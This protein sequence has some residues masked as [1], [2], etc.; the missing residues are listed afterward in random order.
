MKA[1]PAWISAMNPV[2][3]HAAETS[4][5]TSTCLRTEVW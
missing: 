2:D 1:H 5:S 4:L 3:P